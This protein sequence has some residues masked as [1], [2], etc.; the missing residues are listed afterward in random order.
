M[1]THTHTHTN[2]CTRKH[3]PHTR[4]QIVPSMFLVHFC[5][6]FPECCDRRC[7][8][9]PRLV[10]SV[11]NKHVNILLVL[12]CPQHGGSTVFTPSLYLAEKS[13]WSHEELKTHLWQPE[14]LN[15]HLPKIMEILICLPLFI[16]N[17]NSTTIPGH[18]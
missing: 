1:H 6:V 3:R 11:Q 16:R 18:N 5:P 2:L 12:Q 13:K 15:L 9:W 10:I 17:S 8:H 7:I 14:S 4:T